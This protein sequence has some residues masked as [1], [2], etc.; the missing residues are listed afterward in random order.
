METPMNIFYVILCAVGIDSAVLDT[1][2]R[3][4]GNYNYVRGQSG[5]IYVAGYGPHTVPD[6]PTHINITAADLAVYAD[7]IPTLGKSVAIS[8]ID[9]PAEF[10]RLFGLVRCDENGNDIEEGTE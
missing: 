2:G 8:G 5:T 7:Q 6:S 4:S 1:I 9:N 3:V 10:L